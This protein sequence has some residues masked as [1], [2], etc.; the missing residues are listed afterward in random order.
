MK[1]REIIA[2]LEDF[3]PRELQESYDNC[4]LL[5]G[6]PQWETKGAILTLDCIENVIDEAI[7]K[8]ANLIITHHP[9]LFKGLKSITGKTYVERTLI[10]AIKNDIAI[11]A[12]HTNLDNVIHGVNAKIAQKLELKNCRI[13]QTKAQ[14]LK[15]LV[16]FVPTDQAAKIRLALF[17][18]GGG[19]VGN[20]DHCS[21]NVEGYGTFRGGTGSKPYTGQAGQ[22]HEEH[23]T[24]V[25]IIFP[26]YRQNLITNALLN[27]HP[28]EEVAYDIIGLDNSYSGIGSG[29]AGL[30]E[31]EMKPRDFLEYLK[32][33]MNCNLIRHTE[34][35]ARDTVKTVALCGGAGSFLLSTAKAAGAD[36]FISADFK[37]HEFFDADGRIIIADIGHYESEQYTKEIFADVLSQKFPNFALHFSKTDTNPVKYY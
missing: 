20:Y 31:N 33:K 10:K 36:I 28:Y 6:S 4:G 15:K 32:R 8:K 37:Y 34:L 2:C 21:F 27:A 29:M 24:R 18:A 23:E 11:Y 22:D 26:A 19:H 12:C 5:T 3:A 1:I 16:T 9:I 7:D 25:E 14:W 35:A 13:L 17:N 30:L